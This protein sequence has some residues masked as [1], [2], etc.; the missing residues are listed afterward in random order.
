MCD[1]SRQRQ[2][3]PH[4]IFVLSLLLHAASCPTA[5]FVLLQ[6]LG[7]R[8][9]PMSHCEVM[10]V[11][12]FGSPPELMVA[13]YDAHLTCRSWIH[14]PVSVCIRSSALLAPHVLLGGSLLA[15]IWGVKI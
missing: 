4:R 3:V 1:S 8:C 6:R 2:S 14:I 15:R 13:F 9:H 5:H 7:L 12:I 11:I 10:H